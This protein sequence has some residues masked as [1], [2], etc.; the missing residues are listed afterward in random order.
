MTDNG[1]TVQASGLPDYLTVDDSNL[2]VDGTVTISPSRL[3]DQS[4]EI[5][6][7]VGGI[8][9]VTLLLTNTSNSSMTFSLSDDGTLK[10]A[11]S[12]TNQTA[13]MVAFPY[14]GGTPFANWDSNGSAVTN[15]GFDFLFY[16]TVYTNF[17]VSRYG[18]ICFETMVG[19]NTIASLPSGSSPVVA[20]FWGSTSAATNSIRYLKM[21]DKLVVYWSSADNQGFQAWLYPNGQI[22]YVYQGTSW[23]NS[24]ARGVQR[25]SDAV[26]VQEVLPTNV[27]SSPGSRPADVLLTPRSWVTYAPTNG[28]VAGLGSSTVTFTADATGQGVGTNRF[29]AYVT[30]GDGSISPVAVTV[31][32]FNPTSGLTVNPSA[33]TF[34]GIA[35]SITKTNVSLVNTGGMALSYTITDSGAQSS[36]YN[37]ITTNADF[38]WNGIWARPIT[39]WIGGTDGN[40]SPTIPIGFPFPFYGNVY[41]QLSIGVNGRLALGGDRFIAPYWGTLTLDGNASIGYSGDANRLI[42]TWSNMGQDGGGS[43]QTFQAIL[44]RD[45]S[46]RFQYNNLS[47]SSVWPTT[48]IGLQDTLARTKSATLSNETTT[49]YSNVYTST[50]NI[51]VTTNANIWAQSPVTTNITVTVTTNSVL[52]YKNDIANQAIVFAPVSRIVITA[53]PL[54]GTIPVG[55]TNIVTLTGDAR[56]LIAGGANAV[57]NST[58]FNISYTG[59]STPLSAT[60]IATNSTTAAYASA[61]ALADMW[62]ADPVFTSQQNADGSYTLSWTQADDGISRTYRVWYTTSLSSSWIKL[63]PP[64]VNGASYKDIP[65]NEPAIFF[66]VTVE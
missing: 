48:Q 51:T 45:G 9:N 37:G 62:G 5:T 58:T 27:W 52:V 33:A 40:Y 36:G 55:G 28:T 66:K 4:L 31:I 3:K 38:L 35:G 39:A 15:I 56:S 20:P 24:A 41:T 47:G 44:N 23:S 6:V 22:Q 2:F 21:S 34:Y 61:E 12:V 49:V 11:Y 53:D 18:A 14:N 64:V 29:N 43:D 13:A 7:P 26:N 25:G 50:T 60:F 57:T 32:V 30:W 10:T 54:S 19:A 17:S 8:T 1:L 16:G 59:G 46:I 65:R 63:E 42:V